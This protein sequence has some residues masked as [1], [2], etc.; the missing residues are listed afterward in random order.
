MQ[1]AVP[2]EGSPEKKPCSHIGLIRTADEQSISKE[3]NTTDDAGKIIRAGPVPLFLIP[4]TVSAEIHAH[5]GDISRIIITRTRRHAYEISLSK[6][7]SKDQKR[8]G[9]DAD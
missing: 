2:I 9:T 3:I 6:T 8:G 5:G 4:Q 1:P 7:G